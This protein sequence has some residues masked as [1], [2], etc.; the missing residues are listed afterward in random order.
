MN[1]RNLIAHGNRIVIDPNDFFDLW[2]L[3]TEGGMRLDLTEPGAYAF[4]YPIELKPLVDDHSARRFR[5]L[6]Q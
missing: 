4:T 2:I 5:D 1:P 3:M 6:L